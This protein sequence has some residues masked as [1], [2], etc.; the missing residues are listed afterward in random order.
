MIFG[1]QI[2]AGLIG[3]TQLAV[4]SAIVESIAPSPPPKPSDNV[5]YPPR[6]LSGP[7][8]NKQWF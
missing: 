6:R 8:M 4:A 3:I 2:L 1:L 7:D 5:Y